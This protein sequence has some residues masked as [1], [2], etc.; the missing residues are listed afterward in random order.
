M[1]IP[2]QALG[3]LGGKRKE[4]S[5][6]GP[7]AQA[8]SVPQGLTQ[9]GILRSSITPNFSLLPSASSKNKPSKKLGC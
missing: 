9:R 2:N 5:D 4:R 7:A 8:L 6:S 1:T 3:V